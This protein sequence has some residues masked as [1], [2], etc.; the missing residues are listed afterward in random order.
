VQG[1]LYFQYISHGTVET[2]TAR[3]EIL[4]V[5][6]CILLLKM[7]LPVTVHKAPDSGLEA[8]TT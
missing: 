5:F 4:E 6:L 3:M 1:N 2:K 7:S 8:E